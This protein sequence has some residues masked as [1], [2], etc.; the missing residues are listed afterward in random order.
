[1]GKTFKIPQKL[2]KTY[3]FFELT[4]SASTTFNEN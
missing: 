4:T 3:Q 2:K 1:M